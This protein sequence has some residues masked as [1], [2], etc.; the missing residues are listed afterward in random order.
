MQVAD[1]TTP[2]V[3]LHNL[4]RVHNIRAQTCYLNAVIQCLAH[5]HLGEVIAILN[6]ENVVQDSFP[7]VHHLALVMASVRAKRATNI[8]DLWHVLQTANPALF[9]GGQQDMW[10][11]FLYFIAGRWVSAEFGPSYFADT[12]LSEIHQEQ[13]MSNVCALLLQ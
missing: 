6:V 1:E 9:N 8:E 11:V 4:V 2:L 13:A 12:V 7:V 10:D 3:G 5:C